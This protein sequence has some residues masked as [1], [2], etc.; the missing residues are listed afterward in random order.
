VHFHAAAFNAAGLM[1]QGGQDLNLQ[2]AVLETAAL[3]I[4]P[5]PFA[6]ATRQKCSQARK[7]L[8]DFNYLHQC[9]SSP[10]NPKSAPDAPTATILEESSCNGVIAGAP[11]S[12]FVQ[13]EAN[14]HRWRR[15]TILVAEHKVTG[16]TK[17]RS[18]SIRRLNVPELR[19]M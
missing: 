3:P 16:T 14:H 1:Q 10:P 11:P 7:S 13:A 19:S 18:G 12:L 5:P 4:E 8:A 17:L 15:P 6:F 2:P 9:T